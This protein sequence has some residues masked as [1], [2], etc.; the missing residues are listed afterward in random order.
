MWSHR[1]FSGD[2][3][4]DTIVDTGVIRR[5]ALVGGLADR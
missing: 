1:E 2:T 4:V 3:I 5:L